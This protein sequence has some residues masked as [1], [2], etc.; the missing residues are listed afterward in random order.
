MMESFNSE[1]DKKDVPKENDSSTATN[2]NVSSSNDGGLTQLT[3]P[4]TEGTVRSEGD[5]ESNRM[6]FSSLYSLGSVPYGSTR[7]SNTNSIAGSEMDCKS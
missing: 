6:S 5:L 3:I 7:G 1:N 2:H 4:D